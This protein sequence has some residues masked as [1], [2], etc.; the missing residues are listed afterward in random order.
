MASSSTR[1][2]SGSCPAATASRQ[3]ASWARVAG[4]APSAP[5]IASRP[6]SIRW[7]SATSCSRVSSS[8]REASRRNMRTGS[9]VRP[10]EAPLKLPAVRVAASASAAGAASP[11]SP[12]SSVSSSGASSPSSA[13]SPSSQAGRS[14]P[15]TRAT[16]SSK[17]GAP[18]GRETRIS[19]SLSSSIVSV[20]KPSITRS[21]PARATGPLQF[22]RRQ[23][24]SLRKRRNARRAAKAARAGHSRGEKR[25]AKRRTGDVVIYAG[26][27]QPCCA[28][29]RAGLRRRH[30]AG[31]CWSLGITEG[32]GQA[33]AVF[34]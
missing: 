20:T 4:Q 15:G 28:I 8:V 27:N 1:S 17:A 24:G 5:S 34:F 11:S 26:V 10:S 31:R 16:K 14:S 29:G 3:A 7:A 19:V 33:K 9:S 12:S 23:G 13:V 6:A 18:W 32:A 2:R 22:G 21:T 30:D 25:A